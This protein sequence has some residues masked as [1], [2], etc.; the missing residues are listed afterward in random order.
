MLA[1]NNPPQNN[2][3]ANGLS[4]GTFD[5]IIDPQKIYPGHGMQDVEAGDR[6]LI[7]EDIGSEINQDGPDAWK[8]NDGS[9]FIARANDIIEWDGETW[10]VIFNSQ[11]DG[12]HI[13][14]TN[15]YSGVQ[16][17]WNNVSWVRSVDGEYGAGQW[18][19]E[20]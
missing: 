6:F 2:Q 17:L 9:D 10:H 15:I 12:Q 4:A 19:I 8:N 13:Y 18:R 14:Q 1:P 7:I 20:L 11:E 5:A 3:R 16:Y